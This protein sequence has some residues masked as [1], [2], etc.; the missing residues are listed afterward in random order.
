MATSSRQTSIFGIEDWRSLY[1]TYNQADFQSYNFETLRKGFV[2]YLR[3][4]HP[5]DFNDY[6]ESSE[7]IALLDVMAFMGQAISY[8]QDLNTRENF[9]DTAERRDSVVR[10]AD[11]VGYTPKRNENASGFLKVTS[12]STTENITDFNGANL[13]NVTLRWNDSTNIDWQDQFNTVMNAMMVDSQ[14]VGKPGRTADV[15]GNKTDEYTVNLVSNLMPV[16]PFSATVNGANMD[17]EAVS[18]TTANTTSVYEPSPVLNGDFNILYRNDKLGF[19]SANTGFFFYFKQGTLINKDFAL[20]DRIANR[21]VDINVEG[22]N[23]NDVWLYEL[24]NV[25][26]TVINEWEAVQ[27]IYAPIS[28]QTET[29]KR[30]YFSVTSRTNDQI[31]MNFGDGVFGDIPT[32]FFRS[33]VR[34]SNGKK[35]IVNMNDV[36]GINITVPYISR[37]GRAE[38]ATF[39]VTLTQNVT[40]ASTK[41]SIADIKRNAP[42]RFYT[43]NRMVNGEDY[44]NFPYTSFS[45]IIKSK[46]TVRSNIGTSRHLDLVDPTGKYSSVNTFNSDGVIFKELSSN[47]FTFSFDDKND[48]ESIIRNQIEPKLANSSTVHLYHGIFSRSSLS[49]LD[50]A[51]NQ[52]TTSINETT[53]YFKSII[54]SPLSVGTYVSDNRKY[55]VKNSLVK[56]ATPP[57]DING[58]Y[59]FDKHNRLKQ[60]TTLLITDNTVLWTGINNVTLEGTNFGVGNN[61]DG[62]GPITLSNF[63]PNGAVPIEIVHVFNTD[64]PLAFEQSMLS[65]IELY[66]DFGIGYNNTTGTWYIIANT[67]LDKNGEFS[68][69]NAQDVSNTGIDSSWIIKFTANDN[70]Y[71]T[72]TRTLDYYFSSIIETRFYFDGHNKIFDP[73]TGKVVNDFINVLK[74][75]TQPG[76]NAPLSTDIKLD[77]I[78]QPT[79]SDGFVNDFKVE[80]S[81]ADEDGDGIADNPDFFTNL[82]LPTEL[83]FFQTLVDADMLE[84]EMPLPSGIVNDEFASASDPLLNILSYPSGQ[85]FYFVDEVQ[86][87]R[88]LDF[89]VAICETEKYPHSAP[90][91]MV[92]VTDMS[93]KTGRQNLQFQ[94]RHNSAETNRINPGLTNIIDIYVVTAAYHTAYKKYIQDSTNTVTKPS[95][96]TISELT[97]AYQSLQD[98]KMVSD[99]IILN[100]V[101]FKPL[102]GNKAT[103]E[104]RADIAVVK[105]HNVVVSDSEVKSHVVSTINDYFDIENWSFGDTF[106]FSEL[107]AFLH[108]KLG[109]IISS[110]VLVSSDANKK[111]GDLYEIRSASNEIFVN[112]ITV[113]N[114][115]IITSLTSN[116]LN[117]VV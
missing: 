25:T 117:G 116:N 47:S 26:G 93:L 87:F 96:P 7:F 58:I 72:T 14:K 101:V 82:V 59:Y 91:E 69:D 99:N 12:V 48:I 46:A 90:C 92:P 66:N 94:Y 49:A 88:K 3:Q 60:R 34:T 107:S 85:L 62:S 19:A 97:N 32:G 1:K 57:S 37:N 98:S 51:W 9:L 36:S 8:R 112:A 2:D 23:N 74:T 5:E 16:I 108:D 70:I 55:I 114:I 11:L 75:N 78:G 41:E 38:T 33:F 81:Y 28:K 15:L 6:V 83:V 89:T 79:E 10:L 113:D 20:S 111:F 43:Q 45:S 105:V 40:N 50:I 31:T 22:I 68:L 53:G 54:G 103:N 84:R 17:F 4:H 110:V 30:K 104:L 63:I 100:S 95:I 35:Y 106:Y 24:N 42:A 102:F 39:T 76:S 13:A 109:D 77:I 21:N 52:S 86:K 64:L 115:K 67:N 61:A 27:N 29:S 18:A 80:V 71:T 65:R 56:F 44:N 73:K